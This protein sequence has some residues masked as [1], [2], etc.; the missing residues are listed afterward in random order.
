MQYDI[1]SVPLPG[2]PFEAEGGNSPLLKISNTG[3]WLATNVAPGLRPG[4]KC[5][6]TL[7]LDIGRFPVPSF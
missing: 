6:G 7:Q 1:W 2:P 3:G 4:A 5:W